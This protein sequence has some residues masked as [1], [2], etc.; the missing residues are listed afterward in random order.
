[1]AV[2]QEN[3]LRSL[4]GDQNQ[5][6]LGSLNQFNWD[7]NHQEILFL[8]KGL[9]FALNLTFRPPEFLKLTGL[10]VFVLPV[11]AKNDGIFSTLPMLPQKFLVQIFKIF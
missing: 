5:L 10:L 9:I 8:L 2:E 11:F 3:Q 4:Q 6:I 1:M 7:F